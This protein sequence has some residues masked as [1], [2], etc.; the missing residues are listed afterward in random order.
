MGKRKFAAIEVPKALPGTNA[1]LALRTGMY[2][3]T[4][5]RAVSALRKAKLCHIGGWQRVN[6]GE[7]GVHWVPV[8]VAG[9]GRDVPCSF[10][11][12]SR[13]VNNENFVARAKE[14]GHYDVICARKR[15]RY[16]EKKARR[17]D[18]LVNALFG[19][20]HQEQEPCNQ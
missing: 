20:H 15:A 12:R 7:F 4:I 9:A 18:P 1:E 19:A 6:E 17:G 2:P 10:K 8:Y 13:E 14:S 3:N 11:K 5:W 16:W